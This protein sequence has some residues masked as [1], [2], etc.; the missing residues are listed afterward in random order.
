M[1][2]CS[3]NQQKKFKHIIQFE[4]KNYSS[5]R[6]Y[7]SSLTTFNCTSMRKISLWAKHH[8]LQAILFIIII[9]ILLAII[10]FFIGSALLK[11]GF[12]IPFI[13]FIISIIVLLAAV[14]FYPS[15]H[16]A[17]LS[18]KQFYIRQKSCDLAIAICAFVM[19]GTLVNNNFII[20]HST[21]SFASNSIIKTSP[22]AEEILASLQYRDKSSLSKQEKKILKHEFKKQLKVYAKAKLRGKKDEA[23]KALW[24]IL[25]V[26]A[27]VGLLFL[28]A[29][30][31]CSLPCSG[32]EGAAVAVM[33]IGLVAIIWGAVVLIKRISSGPKQKENSPEI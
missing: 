26:I 33:I 13:V 2:Q 31:A 17:G 22:T 30:L 12:Y 25:T 1:Y 11:M 28:L 18:K 23:A 19:I 14:F 8:P 21:V 16:F 7:L 29:A 4:E 5:L 32:A 10:A 9:K 20:P 3:F 6:K 27:A 24:I 15:R